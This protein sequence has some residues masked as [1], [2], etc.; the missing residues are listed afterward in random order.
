MEVAGYA[1]SVNR[2][3]GN[4]LGGEFVTYDISVSLRGYHD[5]L[6][7]K[8]PKINECN[9]G[10]SKG[11]KTTLKQIADLSKINYSGF[12]VQV[13]LGEVNSDSTVNFKSVLDTYK[14][15]EGYYI[16]YSESI[17]RAHKLSSGRTLGLTKNQII[18]TIESTANKP[19]VYDVYELKGK[20]DFKNPTQKVEEFK[21]SLKSNLVKKPPLE[22][23]LIEGDTNPSQAPRGL[24]IVEGQAEVNSVTYKYNVQDLSLNFDK[25]GPRKTK[26][27][28][29]TLNGQPYKE[30]IESWGF[31]Y[32]AIDIENPESFNENKA[33]LVPPLL[34]K[35]PTFELFWTKIEDRT[36][37]YVYKPLAA[38]IGIEAT[39]TT[40][41]GKDKKQKSLGIYYQ[42][43]NDQFTRSPTS[44]NTHKYLVEVVETGWKLGR[45]LTEDLNS[46]AGLDT[47]TDTRTLYHYVINNPDDP[48]ITAEERER[49]ELVW[50]ALQFRKFKVY[51]TKIFSLG[52]ASKYYT[53]IEDIPYRTEKV[54][55]KD[56]VAEDKTGK[57]DLEQDVIIAIPDPN[58][59]FPLLSLQEEE[60]V[61][62]IHT[63]PNPDNVFI[64]A[65]R[66]EIQ[67]SEDSDEEK[68]AALKENPLLPELVV[69]EDSYARTYRKIQPS[70]NTKKDTI[71]VNA[72]IE[73]EW[74]TEFSSSAN[75]QDDDFR[76]SFAQVNFSQRLG[77]PPGPSVLSERFEE[78]DDEEDKEKNTKKEKRYFIQSS[79]ANKDNTIDED[80]QNSGTDLKCLNVTGTL[81]FPTY[82]V[83]K[84][85]QGAE[86]Q[87]KLENWLNSSE[88]RLN[89]AYYYPQ[90][91]PGDFI[92]VMDVPDISDGK[93]RVK[94]VSFSVNWQAN[95]EGTDIVICDGT[96]I[97]CGYW[98]ESLSV[99]L[100]TKDKD[101]EE[102]KLKI[103]PKVFDAEEL[104][105]T[106][107]FR[108]YSRRN[109]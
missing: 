14:T 19:V 103:K 91:K 106:Y 85:K 89:L 25:S 39:E 8:N 95:V 66:K 9:K 41:K 17:V 90:I 54:K 34:G 49:C 79:N 94:S 13:D 58:Y 36:T 46:E 57:L 64:K 2:I 30:R 56:I 16:D 60:I 44:F 108:P 99:D 87:L 102:S 59:V 48:D 22:I 28:T 26:K 82:D 96:S 68:R 50:S 70:K 61:Q 15:L 23:K 77:K 53:N 93:L 37:Q 38:E 20:D 7:A 18:Y 84:A 51:S 4:N 78:P 73:Y 40:T 21:D 65:I 76:S 55:L 47:T 1:E 67:D 6:L 86:N 31:A 10:I 109:R 80:K 32:H 83:D 45:F 11:G 72:D 12:D 98:N 75:S 63:H 100:I 42:N 3:H 81:D 43:S 62:G 74:Y 107:N 71:G 97:T 35:S 88:V 105:Q 92:T 101:E 5:E 69:G 24:D 29:T 27:T 52:E 104:A 33:G